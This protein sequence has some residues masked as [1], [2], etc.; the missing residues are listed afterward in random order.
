MDSACTTIVQHILAAQLGSAER[1][2][3]LAAFVSQFET[4]MSFKAELATDLKQQLVQKL[5]EEFNNTEN[6]FSAQE[7]AHHLTTLR[8]LARENDGMAPLYH[9]ATLHRLMAL[10]GLAQSSLPNLDKPVQIE[11]LKCVINVTLKSD[12]CMT[13]LLAEQGHV[14]AL[15]TVQQGPNSGIT[16]LEA[17]ALFKLL[18]NCTVPNKSGEPDTRSAVVNELLS[19]DLLT[20]V[21]QWLA[22]VLAQLNQGHVSLVVS[23]LVRVMLHATINWGVLAQGSFEDK[24]SD[25]GPENHLKSGGTIIEDKYF[26]EL[27]S[28]IDSLL[29]LLSSTAITWEVRENIVNAFLNIPARYIRIL[30]QRAMHHTIDSICNVLAHQSTSGDPRDMVPTMILLSTV[31]SR[32]GED[33]DPKNTQPRDYLLKKLFPNRDLVTELAEGGN[34]SAPN[35]EPQGCDADTLGNKIIGQMTSLDMAIKYS[36]NELLFQLAEEDPERFVKLTGFGNA[37]GLLA[38]RNLFGMGAHLKQ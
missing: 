32:H 23:E 4:T 8:V 7:L 3:A 22:A 11:A 28:I 18:A 34:S 15:R 30:L 36:A 24:N 35:M 12:T 5:V 14:T 2:Q 21:K 27:E 38:M 33:P 19:R 37:V 16:D 31:A 1:A 17:F 9:T 13:A 20:C 29:A 25:A 10:A 26:A 6:N